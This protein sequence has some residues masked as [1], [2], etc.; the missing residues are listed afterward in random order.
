MLKQILRITTVLLL[1]TQASKA[2][3]YFYNDRYLYS[4]FVFEVSGGPSIL[5]CLTDVGGNKGIGKSFIKDLNLNKT[6]LGGNIAFAV[7]FRDQLTA[8]LESTFGSVSGTDEVLKSKNNPKTGRY[9][10]NLSFRTRIFEMALVAEAH[11]LEIFG[12]VN[13][14]NPSKWSPYVALGVGA[15]RFNP[16]AQLDGKWIDLQPLKTEGQGFRE[17]GK[18]D[19]ALLQLNTIMGLGVR[20]EIN[21]RFGIKGEFLY[22]KL[23]TDYLDDVSGTYIDPSTFGNHFSGAT[24]RIAQALADR[25]TELDPSALAYDGEQRGNS[26]KNDAYFGF[27]FKLVYQFGREKRRY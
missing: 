17:T 1:C 23:N 16:Q 10:R 11:P 15:Y 4:D 8:R 9:E 6:K 2:Q 13:P 12:Q 22:R 7:N 14:E 26:K 5:N 25:R 3:F 20:Y 19:Y 18:Q 21:D 24:L 27:N